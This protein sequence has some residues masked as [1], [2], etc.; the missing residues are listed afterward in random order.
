MTDPSDIYQKPTTQ[1]LPAYRRSVPP[2]H[3]PHIIGT[4]VGILGLGTLYY[5]MHAPEQDAHFAPAARSSTIA[6]PE[7]RDSLIETLR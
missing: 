3:A 6:V 2:S 4:L 1:S 5:V 7:H